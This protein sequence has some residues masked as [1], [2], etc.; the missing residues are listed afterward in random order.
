MCDEMKICSDRKECKIS[1][2]EITND[3]LSA[4]SGL[5]LMLRYIDKTGLFTMIKQKFGHLRKSSKGDLIGEC[6][7]QFM[8]FCMDGTKHSIARFDE[9][10]KDPGVLFPDGDK[11]LPYGIVS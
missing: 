11:P 10:K 4:R 5:S 3:T 6:V 9:L 1:D 7:C 2:V 8:A